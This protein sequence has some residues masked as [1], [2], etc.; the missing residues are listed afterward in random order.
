MSLDIVMSIDI[1]FD[2]LN[3]PWDDWLMLIVY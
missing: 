1:G 3:L 2:I